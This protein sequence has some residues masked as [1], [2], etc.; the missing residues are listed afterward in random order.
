MGKWEIAC[1]IARILSYKYACQL[2][3]QISTEFA[4]LY[5]ES[6]DVKKCKQIAKT[7]DALFLH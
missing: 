3:T 7:S 2:A 1:Q 6:K 4:E 5:S